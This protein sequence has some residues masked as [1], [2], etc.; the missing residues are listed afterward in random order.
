M[1]PRLASNSRS[2][3]FCPQILG[4]LVSPTRLAASGVYFNTEIRNVQLQRHQIG[5]YN[6]DM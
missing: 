5:S 6:Q 3:C 2:C 1:W 4:F